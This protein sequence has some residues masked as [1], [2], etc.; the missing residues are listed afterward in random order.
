MDAAAQ[1][2][3]FSQLSSDVAGNGVVEERL[4]LR[5]IPVRIGSGR[6]FQFGDCEAGRKA[7]VHQEL[8][9]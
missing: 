8:G 7:G 4:V 6:R 3:S 1:V 2:S 9:S 5:L